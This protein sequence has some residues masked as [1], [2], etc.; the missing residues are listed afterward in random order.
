MTVYNTHFDDLHTMDTY[1]GEMRLE[2]KRMVVQVTKG[3]EFMPEHPGYEKYGSKCPPAQ[4]I[5]HD[6]ARYAKAYSPY[7]GVGLDADLGPTEEETKQWADDAGL[8][9]FYIEGV[10]TLPVPGWMHM[11]LK[12]R[13]C[14]LQVQ[15]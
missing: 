11:E 7:V 13:A 9:E 3:L 5:F 6:V 1:Y 15:D 12:A 2:P 4:F 8:T 10:Q 14:E